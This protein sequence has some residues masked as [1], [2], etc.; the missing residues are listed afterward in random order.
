MTKYRVT[1]EIDEE[2]EAD[3][4][5]DAV[6]KAIGKIIGGRAWFENEFTKYIR[7]YGSV[8]EVEEDE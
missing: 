7:D 1:F 4:R 8:E 3:N 2:V 5:D 6:D